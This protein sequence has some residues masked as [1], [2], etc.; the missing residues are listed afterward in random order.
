[1]A[2]NLTPQYLKAEE[3]YRRATTPEE[4]LAALQ[5]MLKEMPKHKSSAAAGGCGDREGWYETIA[6]W[7]GENDNGGARFGTLINAGKY[8]AVY[9]VDAL[10]LAGHGGFERLAQRHPFHRPPIA[11]IWPG[12]YH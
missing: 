2:A 7:C 12:A 10:P 11:S 1:M 9:Y 8:D 3:E 4:E 5:V 6:V